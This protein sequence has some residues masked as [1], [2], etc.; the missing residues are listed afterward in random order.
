MSEK[1]KVYD[2][3][4]HM[5]EH[6][7][8]LEKSKNTYDEV[9]N[10]FVE[11]F[12]IEK[13]SS[14]KNIK[15]ETIQN[16]LS[17]PDKN[18]ENIN[19]LLTYYYIIDG[20]IFQLYDMIFSLPKLDY[21]ITCYDITKSHEKDIAK[22]RQ[23]LERKVKYKRLTRDL[24][25]Q[26][27][28]EGT[29]IGTWLGGKE[30]PYFY[31]FNDLEYVFPMGS[32][33]GNMRA[34]YDLKKLDKMK[35][36][37]RQAQYDNLKPLITENKYN[38]WKSETIKEKKEALRYVILPID[39]TLI[40]RGHTLYRNQRYG[41]PYGTQALFDIQHKQKMKELERS[42]ADKLIR[43]IATLKFRG[44]DDND[45]KVN[46]SA[47]NKVFQAVKTALNK[48][49]KSDNSSISVI[50]IPDFAEFKPTEFDGVDDAL[51]PKKYESVD[52]DTTNATGIPRT[53]TNG[54]KGNFSSANLSLDMIY[55]RIGTMLEEIEEIY[56]QLI[57]IVLGEKKGMNYKF[58]FNKEKPLTKKER[59]DI[60]TKLQAQGYSTKY[61][62][63]ELGL[64]FNDY[65]N[66]SKHEI[67]T[68]KLREIITPP[69]STYTATDSDNNKSSVDNPDN[70][71]TIKSKEIDGDGNPKPSTE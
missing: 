68:L 63:D 16:W 66:Q 39:K 21:K 45:N 26:E 69:L 12:I 32:Y 36:V 43:A 67:E 31:I 71:N 33:K 70:E 13:T 19:N 49:A 34:V 7:N 3:Y 50:A 62:I 5:Q 64:D 6:I 28:H 46:D 55:N 24:L 14:I 35:E 61:I 4:E 9:F 54:T 60:L 8:E 58:E 25:I 30:N 57:V 38:A 53:L 65:I 27:A 56:N 15:I 42:I 47:K 22:L 18:I 51:D 1:N 10:T 59:I 23:I 11:G 48:S 2:S 20:D 17:N 52:D 29:V 41:T 44:K 37:E 40:A